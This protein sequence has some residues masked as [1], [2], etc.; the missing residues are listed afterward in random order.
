MN[1]V[2]SEVDFQ[3]ENNCFYNLLKPVKHKYVKDKKEKQVKLFIPLL[4]FIICAGSINYAKGQDA[5]FSQFYANP[6]YLNPAFAGSEKCTRFV[7]NYRNQPY[8]AFGTFS[9]YSF[10]SDLYNERL[11]GGLGIHLLHDSQG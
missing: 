8:P 1:S 9:S 7:M 3:I 6:L 10:S 5:I 2:N 4:V 11:S